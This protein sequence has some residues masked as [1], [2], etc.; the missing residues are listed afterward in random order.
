MQYSLLSRFQGALVG[1]LVGELLSGDRVKGTSFRVAEELETKSLERS[2]WLA[3]IEDLIG[4]GKLNLEV[5]ERQP[6]MVMGDMALATLPLALFFHEE[7]VMLERQLGQVAIAWNLS[8]EE[9]VGIWAMGLAIAQSLREKLNPQLIIPQ[10]LATQEPPKLTPWLIN[11]QTL[12]EQSAGLDFAVIELSRSAHR[13]Y[14]PLAIALYCF[15][16]T[17]EDFRL[18]VSRAV[19]SGCSPSLTA[20]LTG[21]LSGA[22]NSIAGIPL[23]WRRGV[24]TAISEQTQQLATR[25]LAVWGGVYEVDSSTECQRLAIAAPRIMQLR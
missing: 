14:L 18:S 16:S 19:R 8:E 3:A 5:W 25:L 7:R 6:S 10:I 24:G 13:P 20:A 22:Y 12:L 1:R 11:V 21:A 9:Q 17:P 23:G 2:H 4:S 15:L